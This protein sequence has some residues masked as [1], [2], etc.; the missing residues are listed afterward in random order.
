[1]G[2]KVT[3]R[4]ESVRGQRSFRGAGVRAYFAR[5]DPFGF[6]IGNGH[7]R[8]ARAACRSE[9]EKSAEFARAFFAA[10]RSSMEFASIASTWCTAD[11]AAIHKGKG[12]AVS[13]NGA[14]VQAR[15]ATVL[16]RT[17]MPTIV[18]LPGRRLGT[19]N[20][21]KKL[22]CS[23]C[24]GFDPFVGRKLFWSERECGTDEYRVQGR[25]LP[26]N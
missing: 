26:L 18:A 8:Q 21:V 6:A 17:W 22:S 24:R 12:T 4:I 13:E 5:G 16:R 1:M 3:W 25:V 10:M 20:A 9:G 19:A 7:R 23:D 15:G 14:S 2:A 11:V